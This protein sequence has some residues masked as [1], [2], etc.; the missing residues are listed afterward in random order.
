MP[1]RDRTRRIR[2]LLPCLLVVM[3]LVG[4]VTACGSENDGPRSTAEDFFAAFAATDFAGAAR[5]TTDPARAEAQLRQT[6]DSLTPTSMTASPGRVDINGDVAQVPVSYTWDFGHDRRWKYTS[7]VA[8]GRSDTGWSVRWKSADIHPKLGADQRLSR[9]QT[10]PPRAAVN[11]SDGS[12]VMVDGTVVAV[13]FDAAA[14]AEKNAVSDSVHR[15]VA[16][17]SPLIPGLNAQA[18]AEKATAQSDPLP[19]GR[20]PQEQFDRLRDQLAL[21]G[22]VAAEQAVLT[23]RDPNFAPAVLTSV[24]NTVEGEL[25]GSSG[26]RITVQNPNGMVADVLHDESGKPA[27]AVQ[28]T[29]S[30]MVQNAAQRAVDA[31]AGKQAMLVAIQASTGKILAIAQNRDADRSGLIATSGL[32]PPGS[33]FKMVTSAAAFHDK[34]SAPQDIVPCPGEI[35]IGDRLIPNYDGFSLGSVPLRT[36]FAQSCNTT[37]AHLASRMGS[38]ALTHAAAAMGLG[39]E[40]RVAGL[41]VKSGS[42]PVEPELVMRSVDG[43][44]QGEVLASPLGM[45]LVAAAAASGRAQVPSL[46]GGRETGVVGPTAALDDEVYRQL[47]PMMR[48]VVTEGTATPLA[49]VGEVYGKTGEAEVAGGSHAW[50]AGYRGDIAFATLIVLGGDSTNSVLVTRDFLTMIPGDYRP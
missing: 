3:A 48:A 27:P 19:I 40:Y 37:F 14:A 33:T 24:R 50:F 31:V 20:I 12:E 17:L 43:F 38:T 30:R 9:S 45:A 22:V 36:A 32:Y 7:T 28:L 13:S 21:P 41:S 15:M 2:L 39:Q 25:T 42:V 5:L 47:R 16:V 23:P 18:I 10:D 46:I 26:W 4:S 8:L 6:W 44:G 49:G 35:Q 34:L 11:E 1:S 29:L